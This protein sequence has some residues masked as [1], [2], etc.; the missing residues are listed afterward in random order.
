MRRDVL[1]LLAAGAAVLPSLAAAGP[2]PE[3][4]YPLPEARRTARLMAD[5][6][7]HAVLTAHEMYVREPGQPAAVTWGKQVARKVQARGWPRA[8]IYEASGKPLNPENTADPFDRRA[9]GAFRA[10]KSTHEEATADA[11]RFSIPIRATDATC[12]SCHARNRVGD[13]LGGLT[14]TVP[15]TR[16]SERR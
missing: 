13:L 4:R 11:Y 2:S 10:G 9:A 14:L 6:Y 15:L 1:A 8:R 12:I 7:L 3:Q 5:V 16:G